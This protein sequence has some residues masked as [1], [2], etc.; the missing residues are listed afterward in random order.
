MCRLRGHR[1][2]GMVFQEPMTPSTV[3][4]IGRQ[5]VEPCGCTWPA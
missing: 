2:G 3:H 4:T 5:V 1:I